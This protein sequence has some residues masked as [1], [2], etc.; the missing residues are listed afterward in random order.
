[1]ENQPE[2]VTPE[3]RPVPN[4]REVFVVHG[5][6]DKARIG[7]FDFLRAIDLRPLE[8]SDAIAL[9]GKGSPYVGEVLDAAFSNA[10]A[11]VVLFTPDDEVRLKD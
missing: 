1:M 2:A 11:V 5:R 3:I 6:N 8:W 9:T 10:H 4:T 7:L